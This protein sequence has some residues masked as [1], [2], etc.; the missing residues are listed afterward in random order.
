MKGSYRNLAGAALFALSL[1]PV[2]AQVTSPLPAITTNSGQV[3]GQTLASG[4]KAWFGIPYAQPPTGNLRWREAQPIHWN[5]VFNADRKGPECL[6]ALRSHLLS[7]YF[8]EVATSE[9]CLTLN[10]W[11]APKSTPNSKLP[12]IVF[13]H[14]GGNSVGSGSM[15]QYAGEKLA[16][17]GGILVT[18]NY[19]LRVLGSLAHPELTKEQG[20]KSGNYAY[21]DMVAALQW[22]HDNIGKFG[23]DPAHV[24]V[25]GNSSGA[26]AVFELLM[27]PRAKGLFSA[28]VLDSACANPGG[29]VH[30]F[31]AFRETPLADGEKN[32]LALQEALKVDNLAAMRDAPADK[33]L[34]LNIRGGGAIDGYFLPRPFQETIK[35]HQWNDVPLLWSS[36]ADDIDWGGNPFAT[37][38]TVDE[39]QTAAAKVYGAKAGAFLELYPVKND[40][41]VPA[42]VQRVVIDMGLQQD[43]RTCAKIFHD[44]GGTSPSYFALYAHKS[45]I[46]AGIHYPDPS[47]Y[48]GMPDVD[49]AQNGAVHNF[50][51]PYWF[52][53]YDAFNMLRHTRDITDKDRALSSAM[54]DM[55]IAFA[56][57]GNPSTSKVKLAAWAPDREE[58]VV[59]DDQ[60]KVEK[61]PVKAMDWLAANPVKGQGPACNVG[62]N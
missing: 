6:Q 58:R 60:I 59:L 21:L 35:T 29:T 52:G 47:D 20:G 30:L 40:A 16:A 41:D 3:V 13:I 11:A 39:F 46:A 9:D 56:G 27:S 38:K 2:S 55:L 42:T 49:F 28:A 34:A 22:V 43:Y 31:C 8:G 4:V 19:R 48:P 50:D 18:I 5:G 57:T 12:V 24:A 25:M 10:I 14:G 54:S 17:R 53:G 26:A 32:G 15:P 51:T 23:G 7:Q 45:P 44:D 61:L 37:I 36:N 33:I 1:S 62:S